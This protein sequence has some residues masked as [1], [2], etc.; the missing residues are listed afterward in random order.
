MNIFKHYRLLRKVTSINLSYLHKYL[1]KFAKILT[2]A[3]LVHVKNGDKMSTNVVIM[4][5]NIVDTNH[6]MLHSSLKKIKRSLM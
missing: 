5:S 3:L 1:D 4:K 6:G 2:A